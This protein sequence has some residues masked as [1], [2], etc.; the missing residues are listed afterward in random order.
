MTAPRPLTVG[1]KRTLLGGT[2]RDMAHRL[3]DDAAGAETRSQGLSEGHNQWSLCSAGYLVVVA[4]LECVIND[5]YLDATHG[6]LAGADAKAQR[7]M[8]TYWASK[9]RDFEENEKGVGILKRYNKSLEFAETQRFVA[10]DRTYDEALLLISIRNALTHFVSDW[11]DPANPAG[12]SKV[13][14]DRNWTARNPLRPSRPIDDEGHVL[15]PNHALCADGLTWAIKTADA[16]TE[17]WT[18]RMG[19]KSVWWRID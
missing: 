4:H 14:A 16:L 1:M 7:K 3:R 11:Q 15:F 17:E 13:L 12:M 5:A 2:F 18:H 10:G 19:L 6:T 8:A 9:M